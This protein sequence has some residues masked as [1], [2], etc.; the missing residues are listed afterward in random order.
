MKQKEY[1]KLLELVC[2]KQDSL[3]AHGLWDSEEYKLMERLKVKLKKK[4]RNEENITMKEVLMLLLAMMI[5]FAGG[6]G[7]FA[8]ILH[9]CNGNEKSVSTE[10][11]DFGQSAEVCAESFRGLSNAF[12]TMGENINKGVVKF[13]GDS[14]K[15]TEEEFK[16][17]LR[18]KKGM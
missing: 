11:D 5:G 17:A 18:K 6:T 12:K 10:I 15:M 14:D 13:V 3:L 2:N 4:K 9:Y 1:Q 16:Q 7:M 8:L